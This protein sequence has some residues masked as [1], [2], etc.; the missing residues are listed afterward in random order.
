MRR[1]FYHSIIILL[2]LL[3]CAE[4][5]DAARQKRTVK[6]T[7]KKVIRKKPQKKP[8]ITKVDVE[9]QDERANQSKQIAAR[10]KELISLQ[11]SI[12]DDREKVSALA[13]KEASTTQAISQYRKHSSNIQRF[14][15]LLEEEVESLQD[16]ADDAQNKSNMTASD[17]WR[18]RK[19][20][21]TLVNTAAAKGSPSVS[22]L[23]LVPDAQRNTSLDDEAMRHVS[24]KAASSFRQ[25][26]NKRD[27]LNSQSH[28]LA[29]KSELRTALLQIKSN[30][31]KELDK[32]IAATQKA[33]QKIRTDKTQVLAHMKKS[34]ASAREISNM[35]AELV[36]KSQKPQG[37]KQ[38]TKSTKTATAKSD[39]PPADLPSLK[40]LS[41]H[42]PVSSRKILHGY[43]TYRNPITN[44]QT[45]NP[46]IDIATPNG[47]NVSAV[48]AGTVSMT[49]WLPAYGSVVI[50]DHHNGLRS[51]YANLSSLAIKQG[52]SVQAGQSVGKSGESIDGEFVHIELWHERQRLNPTGY[53]K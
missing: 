24:K 40:A 41:L 19:R 37:K 2:A 15:K 29:T 10:Q 31:Q 9:K 49:H 51:V 39:A 8:T 18:L 50:I 30:E 20:Y 45:N 17:L 21:A 7:V 42:Y 35:I 32:T 33:L 11:K 38:S 27:S 3:I 25:L 14:M 1:T 46:G 26:A 47:S 22:E 6:K 23:L 48:A 16:K 52:Q 12:E 5:S 43:G 28:I 13:A 34:E 53:L 4:Q 44:T 36:T